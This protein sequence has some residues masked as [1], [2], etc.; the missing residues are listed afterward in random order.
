MLRVEWR[1]MSLGGSFFKSMRIDWFFGEQSS[2]QS[3]C[4]QILRKITYIQS[5]TC[6]HWK[7]TTCSQ[8]A[9]CKHWSSAYI[10]SSGCR[11]LEAPPTS[12][13]VSLWGSAY[14]L[15][16]GNCS[17]IVRLTSETK[18][19]EYNGLLSDPL[20]LQ[21]TQ[22]VA[23]NATVTIERLSYKT[24][25]WNCLEA[26][27]LAHQRRLLT[28]FIYFSVSSKTQRTLLTDCIVRS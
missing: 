4:L 19:R 21:I 13:Q 20:L 25:S 22:F 7:N 5:D 1:A 6:K 3:D 11:C 9:A 16:H 14:E 18:L 12:N 10:Q 15:M 24:I 28:G 2:D 27:S 23:F 17:T 8:S 26:S